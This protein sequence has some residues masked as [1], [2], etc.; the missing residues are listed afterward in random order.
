MPRARPLQPSLNAGEFSPRMAARTDFA[1]YPLACGTLL[2]MVPI[3]QGGAMRRPGTRFVAETKNSA[4][5]SRLIPFEFSTAQAYVVEAG[6]GYLR[7]YRNQG[8]IGTA[9]TDAAIV[10]GT[11]TAGI[12]GWSELSSGTASIGHDAANGRLN[13]NGAASSVAIAEQAVSLSAGF[14]GTAHVVSFRVCGVAGDTVKLRIGTTS[15]ATNVVNDVAFAT[16]WHCYA[17]TPAGSP[18]YLQFRNE[19]AKTVKID[20]V[21]IHDDAPVEIGAPYAEADLSGIKYAQSADVLYL[22][23]RS[24]PVMKLARYGHT[25]WSLSEAP[26]NDGPW[27]KANIET[28][29]TLQP[30]ATSGFGITITAAGHSPFAATDV[31]RLVR[32]KHGSAWGSAVITGHTSATQVSADVQNAFGGTSASSDWRLGAWGQGAPGFPGAVTFFEQRLCFA[33]SLSQPQT[34]W[35]SQSADFENFRPDNGSGTVEDDDALDYTI[36]AD[37]VNAIRWLWAGPQLVVGT[38][39]GEWVVS[40][41][42]PLITPADI[43]VKRQTAFGAADL[44]PINMR[45]RL[46]FLQRAQRKILEFLYSLDVQNWQAT[47]LT[48]LAS[49]VSKGGIVDL[50]YQ[51]ELDSCLWCVRADGVLPTLTYQPDQNVVGWARQILGGRC[52]G[53]EAAAEAV[54]CIPGAAQN[55]VWLTVRRTINGTTRRT[56]EFVEA[57]YDTGDDPSNALYADC[58]LTFDAKVNATL[59]PGAPSGGAVTFTAGAP[60]FGAGDVGREIHHAYQDDDGAWRLARARI[61]SFVSATVV[62]ADVL[63]PFPS[64]ATIPAN[65]WALTATAVAGLGHLEGETVAVLANG[66]VHPPRVV[67]GGQIALDYP[68]SKAQIGLPYAHVYESLKWEAGA[69]AGTAQGQMKQISGV[70]LVLLDALNA[71]VGPSLDRLRTVPFRGVDDPMSA[72]VPLFTGEKFI[73]FDGGYA[74]DTRVVIEGSDPLP[75][76]LLALA[77]EIRTNAR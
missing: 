4:K 68:V 74:T 6:E 11:F 48:I 14:L 70:T 21:T 46:L 30:S 19:T 59:T 55:E 22:C 65:G 52:D 1:K 16:G 56:V 51:Q 12:S 39:G 20:D 10:N 44:P 49:H 50:T 63:V 28:A 40:S 60:A 66:A 35:M 54:A 17:F 77:P 58:G 42:G 3:P 76:T 45:G 18:V 32:I 33:G 64:A 29:R 7:F 31:G 62:S 37:Q 24:Y 71:R 5:R 25:S 36:S 34:I 67:I 73:E 13:L 15:G 26:F 43:D 47:D 27:L 61:V 53:G 9:D 41:D 75:F 38:V 72:A 2:N 69:V 23:H 57:P 8:R